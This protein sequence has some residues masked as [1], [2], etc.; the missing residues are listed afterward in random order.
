MARR[1]VKV[2]LTKPKHLFSK[3]QIEALISDQRKEKLTIRER[4]LYCTKTGDKWD[5]Y[6]HAR[7]IDPKSNDDKEIVTSCSRLSLFCNKLLKAG[8]ARELIDMYAKDPDVITA[9]NKIQKEQTEQNLADN[10][11]RTPLHFS[12]ANVRK[13]I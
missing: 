4:A 13:R 6:I 8:I 12:L 9:S 7:E 2:A 5:I 3:E 11:S 1:C 10:R